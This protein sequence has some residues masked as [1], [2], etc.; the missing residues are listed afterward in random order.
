M[1]EI[2]RKPGEHPYKPTEKEMFMVDTFNGLLEDKDE[3]LN[4]KFLKIGKA[5]KRI[6]ETFEQGLSVDDVVLKNVI[7][8]KAS[9]EWLELNA[10][11]EQLKEEE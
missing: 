1:V 3:D 2:K 8:K 6:L 10:I 7:L 4:V 9:K 11:V 5:K